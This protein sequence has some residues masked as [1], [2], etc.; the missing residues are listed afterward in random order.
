MQL[1]IEFGAADSV[2][3][4]FPSPFEALLAKR[5]AAPSRACNQSIL[6]EQESVK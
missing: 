3:Q 4:T 5:L 6:F 1:G 2:D